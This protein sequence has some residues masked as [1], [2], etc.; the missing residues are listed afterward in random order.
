MTQKLENLPIENIADKLVD[1]LDNLDNLLKDPEI[2]ELLHNLNEDSKKLGG[3]IENTDK[4]VLNADGRVTE[5]SDSV[6]MT[7][8]D[9]QKVLQNAS[10]NLDGVSSDAKK[11]LQGLDGQIKPVMQRIE[12][13][14]NS[15]NNALQDAT[16]TLVTVNG[17]VG[18]RSGTR[19]KLN[20]ALDEIAAAAKSMKSL[21]DY[22]ERHPNALLM[23]KGGAK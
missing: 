15:A 7:L 3:A 16:K 20:R 5:I 14:L 12:T 1:I 6:Q 10:R 18:E 21:L 2:K 22:L 9:A 19:N 4:L 11:L 8:S 13:V 17:F 23:G